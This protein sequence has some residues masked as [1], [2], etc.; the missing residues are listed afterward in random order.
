MRKD[1]GTSLCHH[2]YRACYSLTLHLHRTLPQLKG[3]NKT[4]FQILFPFKGVCQ[5][6]IFQW[7]FVRE[8]TGSLTATFFQ[9][10]VAKAWL[11]RVQAYGDRV[12]HTNWSQLLTGGVALAWL[13]PSLNS[14]SCSDYWTHFRA[15]VRDEGSKNCMD[16]TYL[17]VN[18]H[19][20]KP[21]LLS[22][23]CGCVPLLL[24][25]CLCV[26]RLLLALAPRNTS[27]IW[28]PLFVKHY[29]PLL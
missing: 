5:I 8:R 7:F 11:L 12:V 10:L 24:T 16:C 6:V 29:L 21:L 4:V 25:V 14:T 20:C 28:A 22:V 15:E 19:W 1:G 27:R 18:G 23:C 13:R 3:V 26:K 9:G 17:H 2:L